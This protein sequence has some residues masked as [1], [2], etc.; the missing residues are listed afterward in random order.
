MLAPL[1]SMH[2]FWGVF[3]Q[4]LLAGL[5]GI[6][7]GLLVLFCLGSREL[8]ALVSALRKKFWK[9]DLVDPEPVQ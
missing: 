6:L 3:L 4:G 9:V 5:G 1:F 2:T 8:G 7:A